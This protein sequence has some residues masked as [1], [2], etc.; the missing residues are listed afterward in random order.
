MNWT[1]LGDGGFFNSRQNQTA[2]LEKRI[3]EI[4][5]FNTRR[6]LEVKVR[7]IFKTL[8]FLEQKVDVATFQRKNAQKNYDSVLDNY[9][10]AR[11]N[12][13][14]IKFAVD[15]LVLSTINEENVKYQHLQKKLELADYMGLEDFP[16]ENFETL[17]A[18]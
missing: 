6:L 7:T 1:I 18:R 11:A 4:N 8:R 16:G 13:S 2:Y 5:Y 10:G 15:N 17:A 3:T 9:M 12:Y 14:D